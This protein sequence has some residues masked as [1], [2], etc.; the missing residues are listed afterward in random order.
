[1]LV[2][3][4]A[5]NGRSYYVSSHCRASFPSRS[6]FILIQLADIDIIEINIFILRNLNF[7]LQSGNN[8][9]VLIRGLDS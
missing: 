6:N 5:Y 1:M 4:I 8:L 2:I 9:F 7:L 3:V